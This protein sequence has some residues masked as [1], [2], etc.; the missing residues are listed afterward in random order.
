MLILCE[1]GKNGHV[2][3][4]ILININYLSKFWTEVEVRFGIKHCDVDLNDSISELDEDFHILPGYNFINTTSDKQDAVL[5]CGF[6]LA[7]KTLLLLFFFIHFSIHY[8]D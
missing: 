4:V 6:D 5:C 2:K 3:H 1:K 8:I 7:I